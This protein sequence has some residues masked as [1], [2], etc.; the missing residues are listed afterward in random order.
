MQEGLLQF[1]QGGEFAFA[2][3]GEVHSLGWAIARLFALH[4][5]PGIQCVSKGLT[6]IDQ[7]ITIDHASPSSSNP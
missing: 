2:E 5:Q 4:R 6:I 1:L 7:L 3:V